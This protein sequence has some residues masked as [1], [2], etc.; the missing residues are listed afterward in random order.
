MQHHAMSLRCK[1]STRSPS[2]DARMAIRVTTRD[3][4]L[5]ARV[6]HQWKDDEDLPIASVA[7]Y[8]SL[9]RRPFKDLSEGILR[10]SLT[11][12]HRLQCALYRCRAERSPFY[13]ARAHGYPT[14][15]IEAA[16]S[17][18]QSALARTCTTF[19]TF[20]PP[21]TTSFSPSIPPTHLSQPYS[22]MPGLTTAQVSL[23][24]AVSP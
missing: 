7:V 24:D 17:A 10:V 23:V 21:W 3:H 4:Q 13:R 14:C 18:A 20:R 16:M 12:W 11:D 6:A 22:T 2:E 5:K 1:R 19:L 9:S 15:D 8:G